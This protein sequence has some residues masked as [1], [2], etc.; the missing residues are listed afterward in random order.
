MSAF[1]D[2]LTKGRL[3]KIDPDVELIARELG[4]AKEE[5]ER[6]R[7]SCASGNWND[8]AMQ[9]YFVLTRCAR[10]AVNARGYKD[11]NLYGLQIALEHLFIEPGELDKAITKQIRDAKDVKDAVYSGRR[12]SPYESK[13]M[14]MWAQK[15]A[16]FVFGRLALPGFDGEQ[17]P[18][19]IP[20][21]VSPPPRD[22]AAIDDGQQAMG[23][24]EPPRHGE[25]R[26]RS[27]IG[28]RQDRPRR[29]DPNRQ[30]EFN[31]G[32]DPNRRPD[33][34]RSSSLGRTP[35]PSRVPEWRR[36]DPQRPR[37]LPPPDEDED[38][39]ESK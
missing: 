39:A 10:A 26:P 13:Q 27:D 38:T 15:F 14:L 30:P 24:G 36:P 33:W 1:D 6:A 11:T 20:E 25:W 29:Y 18:T 5:L 21:P 37:W 2:C 22:V 32:P 19:N 23:V 12:S 35:G 4:T 9:S 7:L 17:V 16:K 8:T 34:T 31:R 28:P 3:K